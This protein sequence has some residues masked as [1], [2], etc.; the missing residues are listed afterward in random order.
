[1]TNK[2]MGTHQEGKSPEQLIEEME[3]Y[4]KSPSY[5]DVEETFGTDTA[6]KATNNTAIIGISAVTIVI[7]ACIAMCGL[8]FIVFLL[9][10]PW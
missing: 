4:D 6:D 3:N 9:N 2:E 1:M 8:I 10:A 5:S 7:L